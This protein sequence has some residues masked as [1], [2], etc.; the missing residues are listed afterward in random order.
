MSGSSRHRDLCLRSFRAIF[1]PNEPFVQEPPSGVKMANA[2]SLHGTPH[3]DRRCSSRLLSYDEA[4]TFSATQAM[5]SCRLI[6]PIIFT[7]L[8]YGGSQ[9][10]CVI[11]SP[12]ESFCL[13]SGHGEYPT[14]YIGQRQS[15][16]VPER[17]RLL[18]KVL[19]NTMHGNEHI[20]DHR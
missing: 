10:I 2:A 16:E 11:S 18:F 1:F 12:K 14:T 17:I 5:I 9:H 8:A 20:G 15:V 4:V 13:S 7:Q 3:T 19:G 6:R